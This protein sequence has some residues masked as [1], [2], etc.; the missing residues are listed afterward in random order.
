M[1]IINFTI[2]QKVY[3]DVNFTGIEET[4]VGSVG[5]IKICLKFVCEHELPANWRDVFDNTININE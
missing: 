1:I 3:G 5:E 2:E 4:P